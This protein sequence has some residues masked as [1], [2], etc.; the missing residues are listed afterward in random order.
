MRAPRY[1]TV[2]VLLCGRRRGGLYPL[3]GHPRRPGSDRRRF[4][5][6][7]YRSRPGS[8]GAKANAFVLET[9]KGKLSALYS[10]GRQRRFVKDFM[11]CVG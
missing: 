8:S 5:R 6:M 9:P 4:T 11:D 1:G 3:A 7:V 2:P 10:S